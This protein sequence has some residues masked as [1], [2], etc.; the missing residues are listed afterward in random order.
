MNQNAP[1]DW[2]MT[3]IHAFCGGIF[4][5]AMSLR[6]GTGWGILIAAIAMAVFAAVYLD[7]FWDWLMTWWRSF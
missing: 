1:R 2:E 4:G 5:V 7:R 6:W 3:W